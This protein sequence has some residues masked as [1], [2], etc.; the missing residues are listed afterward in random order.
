MSNEEVMLA[1][2]RGEEMMDETQ[3]EEYS[4]LVEQLG[5][6]AVCNANSN[7]LRQ[8]FFRFSK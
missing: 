2:E 5:D 8:L 6:R 1:D 7:R 4:E 3:L